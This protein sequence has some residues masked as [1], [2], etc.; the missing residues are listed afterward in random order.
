MI[1]GSSK[2]TGGPFTR[3]DPSDPGSEE[4]KSALDFIIVHSD[5]GKYVESMKIDSKLLF[6]PYRVKSKAKL[7]YSDHYAI[8]LNFKDIPIADQKVRN[9]VRHTIWN[10]RKEEGWANY[11]E[12]T[13][14]NKRI[15]K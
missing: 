9:G 14:S 3:Y 12:K 7:V 13:K 10:I 2:E 1:N 5:L 11:F 4:K 15:E 8:L 6:T